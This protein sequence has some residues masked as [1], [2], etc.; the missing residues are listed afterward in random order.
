MPAITDYAGYGNRY[1]AG[2]ADESTE[3]ALKYAFGWTQYEGHGPGDEIL[4]EPATALEL[5]SSYSASRLGGGGISLV[6]GSYKVRPPS[7]WRGRAADGRRS[8][9]SGTPPGSRIPIG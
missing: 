7:S 6:P 3:D 2:V 8:T 4:G 9:R 5:G 1:A